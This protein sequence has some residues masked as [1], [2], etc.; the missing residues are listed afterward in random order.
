MKSLKG[1]LVILLLLASPL[2]AET[3]TVKIGNLPRSI[4][5]YSGTPCAPSPNARK[6]HFVKLDDARAEIKQKHS[7]YQK[8][9]TCRVVREYI[10][11]PEEVHLSVYDQ[12]I[13]SMT[14]VP[15]IRGDQ[16]KVRVYYSPVN[17]ADKTHTLDGNGHRD[18][19]AGI[20]ERKR[21]LEWH[22]H[23]RLGC[24]SPS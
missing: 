7:I 19:R 10:D 9:M 18:A 21:E 17:V 20:I 5:R 8:L 3:R 6:V 22:S 11:A 24:T 12:L 2:L 13:R 14:G 23:G 1:S 15:S 16:P 4:E